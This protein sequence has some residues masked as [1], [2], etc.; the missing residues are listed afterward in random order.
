MF[1]GKAPDVELEKLLEIYK[2]LDPLFK[3]YI[4]LQIKQLLNLQNRS[5]EQ[6]QLTN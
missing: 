2:E 1:C 3:E 5:K 6:K 4:I